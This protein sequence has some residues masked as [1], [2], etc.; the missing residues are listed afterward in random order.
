MPRYFFDTEDGERAIQ[1]K[2]GIELSTF[3][4]IRATV[5]D[6]LFDLGHAEL[7]S[8]RDRMFTAVVRD[9]QGIPVYRGSMT[10]KMDLVRPNTKGRA[11]QVPVGTIRLACAVLIT[12]SSFPISDLILDGSATSWAL[13]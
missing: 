13:T 8:G 10:L 11:W 9:E 3:D 12:W 4:D 7:L 5:R 6:L 2:V 1:D